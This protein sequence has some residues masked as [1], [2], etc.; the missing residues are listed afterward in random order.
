MTRIAGLPLERSQVSGLYLPGAISLS[1]AL[2]EKGER[3][4]AVRV[5]QE[6]SE[7]KSRSYIYRV[8]WMNAQLLLAERYRELGYEAEAREIEEE[9]LGLLAYADPDFPLLLRLQGVRN[10]TTRNNS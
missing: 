10:A 7:L 5:L 9:L 6:T 1:R 2:L 8:D 4:R 3:T